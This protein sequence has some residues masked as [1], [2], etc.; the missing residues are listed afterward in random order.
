M[1]FHNI[2]GIIRE[3]KITAG[4][5]VKFGILHL[6]VDT[7]QRISRKDAKTQSKEKKETLRLCVRIIFTKRVNYFRDSVKDAD[8]D[9]VIIGAGIAGASIARQLCR[10]QLRVALLEKEADVAFGVSKANSI[11]VHAGFHSKPGAFE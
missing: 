3:P 6:P 10:Y 8:Y 9:V 11:I 4:L 5:S 2:T 1:L 7:F